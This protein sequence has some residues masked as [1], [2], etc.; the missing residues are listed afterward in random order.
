[1]S[2]DLLSRCAVLDTTTVSDALDRFG[3]PSGVGGLRA[4]TITGPVVGFARTA[5]MEPFRGEAAGAHILT[6]VVA[7]AGD[8][9]VLV[10]DND[11]RTDVSIWGGILSAAAAD[12]RVRGVIVDG[13]CRDVAETRDIG[14]T[15]Y[16]RGATPAT[17][18]GRLRQTSSGEPVRIA[19]PTVHDGD[20]VI[21]DDSGFVVVPRDRADE[22][23]AEAE[24]V[25]AREAAIAA[26]VRS[27]A[28]LP[29]AMRDARLAGQHEQMVEQS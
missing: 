26:D 14:L 6:D 10:I 3:L 23:I 8:E 17:A 9:D 12:R 20:V 19:G 15:V 27:G 29:G 2:N 4:M 25:A 5:A 22:V 24:A 18:R 21:A 1:M 11:G 16:A 7:A 13:A 28:D